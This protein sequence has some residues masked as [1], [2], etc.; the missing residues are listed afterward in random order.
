MTDQRA[1]CMG[2]A[3]HDEHEFNGGMH[4]PGFRSE[5]LDAAVLEGAGRTWQDT[6]HRAMLRYFTEHGA[7]MAHR[8]EEHEQYGD[9]GELSSYVVRRILKED[10]HPQQR[11]DQVREHVLS[12]GV[13]LA[14]SSVVQETDWTRWGG[15]FADDEFIQGLKVEVTC[16]CGQ[17]QR[18]GFRLE[19]T[20]TAELINGLMAYDGH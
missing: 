17:Q 5:E 6:Y 7:V 16:R 1:E 15:S 4:C 8:D 13:D 19:R 3:P 2:S 18:R 11:P 12:C 20:S 14:K 10:D 9:R